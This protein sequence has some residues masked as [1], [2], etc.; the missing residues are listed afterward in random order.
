MSHAFEIKL[1]REIFGSRSV[2][3]EDMKK[4]EP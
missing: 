1:E 4:T 2:P 3:E